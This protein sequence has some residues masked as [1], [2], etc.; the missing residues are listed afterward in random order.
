MQQTPSG[1][2]QHT[3]NTEQQEQRRDARAGSGFNALVALRVLTVV[4]DNV[5]RWLA[6]GLGKQAVTGGQV[7]VVLTVGTAGF[8]LP[9]VLLAWLAGYLADRYPKR[10]VIMWCKFAEILI[11][12][13]AAAAVAWGVRSG[14]SFIGLPAGLW[15]LLGTVVVIGCQAALLAPSVIGTIPEI[16]PV[17]KLSHAN[18]I[19]AMATLAATLVGMAGGNWLADSTP[20]P[21]S[22]SVVHSAPMVAHAVPSAIALIGLAV[23]GWIA[24]WM[25]VPRVAAA[26]TMR[27]PW[28]AMARTGADLADL[29]R[30]K[31]LSATA[32]G[33]VF[34]WA[35]GAVAQLNVDQF[36]SEG[37]A[38]SQSQIVPLLLSLVLGIGLGSVCA[39]KL[40]PRGVNR[41]LVPIGAIVMAVA[42]VCLAYSPQPIFLA[43]GSYGLAWWFAAVALSLLG[44]GAGVFDVPLEAYFQ[45][46]SP[47]ARRGSL[48]AITN[49]LTFAGIFVASLIYG[50]LRSPLAAAVSGVEA[51]P[52]LSA[53]SIFGIFGGMSFA[54]AAVAVYAAPRASLRMLV[55]SLVGLLYRFRVKHADRMPATGPVVV[56][57]NHL[58]WLDGFIVVLAGLRPI[59]LVVYAPNIQGKFMRM[60]ADQ[61][62]FILF[63]PR[64]KS[65]GTAMKTIQSGLANGD[66]VGIFSEGGI[67]RTGQILGFKRG[68]EWILQRVES[69]IVPLHIDGMWGSL[70]SFSEGRYFTKWPRGLRRPLTLTFGSPLPI[71]TSGHAARLAIQE[72]T[73]VAVRERLRQSRSADRELMAWLRRFR[74]DVVAICADGSRHTG[75]DVLK[76]LERANAKA[77]FENGSHSAAP[78]D[79]LAACS[80]LLAGVPLDLAT[81]Q[82]AAPSAIDAQATGLRAS[83]PELSR[84]HIPRQL[85]AIDSARSQGLDWAALAAGAEAFDGACLVR[86][87]DRLLTSLEPGDPL[88]VQLGLYGGALLGIRAVVADRARSTQL[89]ADVIASEGITIWVARAEQVRAMAFERVRPA[90]TLQ[91]VVMPLDDYA[92]LSGT[93]Q[94]ANEFREAFGIEPVVAFAPR[95][96]GGLVAMNTPPARAA[97]DHE[98]V[99]KRDTV[100]RVINGVVVWPQASMREKLGRPSLASRVILAEESG[101]LAIGAT[102]AVPFEQS[103]DDSPAACL[104]DTA[105]DVD[106]DGFLVPVL[107]G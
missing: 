101:T 45:E 11:A 67:S 99:F 47:A 82:P 19:F 5:L 86:R 22:D 1:P 52:L 16:V 7:A 3:Q 24:A 10:S 71:G 8:V 50:L 6:I 26:P 97:A 89:L 74:N 87:D 61:W 80:A 32:A 30:R 79:L 70:L 75:A 27:P 103:Q 98:I 4:N 55:A 84:R 42:S 46:Q 92:Q 38:T 64:P 102:L 33:I 17:N 62:R 93:Q 21:G 41:G 51:A 95:G 31:E 90:Q 85:I 43:D 72:L 69:P 59:R 37:G 91:A 76:E 23:A 53:R 35:L 2:K 39:G 73:A 77:V 104:L 48:L 18:G 40:S 81:G 68:L 66:A 9:F 44:F 88:F 105:F 13:A 12:A 60:L 96:T 29:F 14:D 83:T 56:V 78:G 57:A 15:L 94:A 28:N 63:D 36:A 107:E 100:G 49:L 34:F 25:L 20:V 54:A 65:I 106:K 58:S